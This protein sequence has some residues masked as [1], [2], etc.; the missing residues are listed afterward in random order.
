[1][2]GHEGTGRCMCSEACGRACCAQRCGVF[3]AC[4]IGWVC[5]LV[6]GGVA[7]MGGVAWVVHGRT[8]GGAWEEDAR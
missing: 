3:I 6:W 2:S 4:I 5:V 8:E 7:C 1:M